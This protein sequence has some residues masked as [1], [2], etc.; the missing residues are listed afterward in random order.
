MLKQK[1]K[2]NFAV[3]STPNSNV[4]IRIGDRDF[5]PV[6][7]DASGK[8]SIPIIAPPE[9]SEATK[10]KIVQWRKKRRTIDLRIP[11]NVPRFNIF[12]TLEKHV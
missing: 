4:I 10:I 3:N 12:P 11:R 7:T 1:G 9:A 6:Q 2:T 5:G 8:A